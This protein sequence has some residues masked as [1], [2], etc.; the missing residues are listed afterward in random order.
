ML[1]CLREP[2]QHNATLLSGIWSDEITLERSDE[3]VTG[4]GKPNVRKVNGKLSL[5]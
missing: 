2:S 1:T 3:S 5:R 4:N